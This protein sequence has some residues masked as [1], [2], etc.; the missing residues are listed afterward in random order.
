MALLYPTLAHIQKSKYKPEDG[1]IRLLTFLENNLSDEYEVYFQPF[2]NGDRPDIVLMRRGSGVLVIEVK[3]WHLP[4]Y[5]IDEDG[6]WRIAANNARTKS[7]L[8][9][10]KAYKDNLYDLHIDHLLSKKIKNEKFYAIVSCAVYFHCASENDVVEFCGSAGYTE[11]MGH[12]SLTAS[13]FSILL[14]RHWLNKQSLYFDDS[15]YE[16][17][18]RYLQPPLHAMLHGIEIGYRGKQKELIESR[19]VE[20]KV[21]GVAGSGKTKVLAKRAVNSYLRTNER[22][23]ILTFNITLRNYIHDKINEV[24]EN[25]SWGNFY[26]TH[27]H[28]FFAIEA[29]NH[30]L[31]VSNLLVDCY[32]EHFFEPVKDKIKKYSAIFVDEVQDQETAWIRIV[33]KYFLKAGGEFVVFGDEKQNVYQRTMAEDKKPNTTVVGRWNELNDSFRASSRIIHLAFEFQDRFF[34]NKYELD[35]INIIEQP[36]LFSQPQY[37]SQL[38]FDKN[39]QVTEIYNQLDNV[40]KTLDIHPNDICIV[41]S[42]VELL[43]ELDF[44][45]RSQSHERTAIAFETK[46]EYAALNGSL[47]IETLRR[48]RKFQFWMNTGTIK[49][50]TIHSFKGWEVHTLVLVIDNEVA[51]DDFT[52]DELIYTAITRC[53]QNL[54]VINLDN[55]K[56]AGFFDHYTDSLPNKK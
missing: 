36:D 40:L 30:D 50:A 21:R 54:V 9:Q 28:L 23:L 22:V 11:L 41:S 5:F 47:D 2:L 34:G 19:P 8:D 43:R 31:E 16:S 56:Y 6:C 44:L 45:I 13:K 55:K 4:S 27:Y 14:S 20:Q 46:E 51:G 24:R 25:F 52:T 12:D 38:S 32:D 53:R 33:K 35:D 1:E 39:A 48:S 3:D 7:P 49:L 37:V 26:V 17:F 10:V 29:N 42:K 18:K 15:L